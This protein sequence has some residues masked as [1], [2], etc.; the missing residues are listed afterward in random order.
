MLY[1]NTLRNKI[2]MINVVMG[3]SIFLKTY[4]YVYFYVSLCIKQDNFF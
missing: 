2:V 3:V 1:N 4:F